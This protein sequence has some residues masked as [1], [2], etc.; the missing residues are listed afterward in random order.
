VQPPGS[1]REQ[2][3]QSSHMAPADWVGTVLAGCAAAGAG[4]DGVDAAGVDFPE[5][6][7]QR[8][9]TSGSGGSRRE[10]RLH[11]AESP[12]VAL[13]DGVCGF[14]GV[15]AAGAGVSAGACAATGSATGAAA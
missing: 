11:E 15:A 7:L 4:C 12:V 1:R 2:R 9:G 6:R 3:V 5:Q 13:A 10:Q 14:E 8:P